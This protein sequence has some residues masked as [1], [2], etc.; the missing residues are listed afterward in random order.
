M[1]PSAK[2]WDR[3][4]AR[5]ARSPVADEAAYREKL[6]ITQGYLRPGMEVL[7]FGCG[8]G[9]TA[10]EHAPFV[11]H[12]LATDISAQM[13]RIAEAKAR[14]K[15]VG[16]VTFRQAVLEE[17]PRPAEGFDAILGLSILH[18]VAHR[19]AAIAD[20]YRL[21]K[22][23]GVF[24][25]ST[26]CLGDWLRIFRLIGPIGRALGLLPLVRVFTARELEDSMTR[27][28]FVIERR[29]LPRRRAALFLVARRP[30]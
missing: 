3:I 20:A 30:G 15:S 23:G 25:S 18:L 12:I 26:A 4:A 27:A 21:L 8:T 9:S 5:Y 29:W 22:P 7:E 2:F 28:G 6:R 16:N 13:L 1:R 10:L 24:V 14:E 11:K 19:D 17:I